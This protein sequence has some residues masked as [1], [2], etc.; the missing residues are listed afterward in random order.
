LALGFPALGSVVTI[1]GGLGNDLAIKS[2]VIKITPE[3]GIQLDLLQDSIFEGSPAFTD[4]GRLIGFM[5]EGFFPGPTDIY[6]ARDF[7]KF[8]PVA[9]SK[10]PFFTITPVAPG[11]VMK[12]KKKLENY[13]RDTQL[14]LDD[15]RGDPGAYMEMRRACRYIPTELGFRL[16]HS[17]ANGGFLVVALPNNVDKQGVLMFDRTYG[18]GNLPIETYPDSD[19]KLRTDFTKANVMAITQI[20]YT[21]FNGITIDSKFGDRFFD[22]ALAELEKYADFDKPISLTAVLEF[23]GGLA[24]VTRTYTLFARTLSE[25][26]RYGKSQTRQNHEQSDLVMRIH[27]RLPAINGIRVPDGLRIEDTAA[28]LPEAL[29]LDTRWYNLRNPDFNFFGGGQAY[30]GPTVLDYK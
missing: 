21:N 7:I 23:A 25:I 28:F 16:V 26:D 22:Y 24:S 19:P 30:P 29:E 2:Q 4:E 17:H 18:P 14:T 11:F 8:N 27:P 9:R 10:V 20:I 5:K 12:S 13:L 1:Y 15:L 3:G 6:P